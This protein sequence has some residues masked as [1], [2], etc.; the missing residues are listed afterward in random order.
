MRPALALSFCLVASS[1]AT[2]ERAT[3]NDVD[4]DAVKRVEPKAAAPTKPSEMIAGASAG[5]LI[6]RAL[7]RFL[8]ERVEARHAEKTSAVWASAWD[9]AL[10]AVS[11]ACEE[12]P[13]ASDLGAFVRARVT[14][15]VELEKD[16]ERGVLLP[17]DV[18]K[19]LSAVLGAVDESV[20]ELRAANA[21]GTMAPSPRL[22][23]GELVIHAPLFPL[24]INSPFGVREDPFTHQK[25]YHNGVDLD[26]RLGDPVMAAAAGLVVYAGLQG[27]Y[28]KQ[29]VLDHGD[30]VRTHYSHLSKILV[31]PGQTVAEG[32]AIALVGS[33]GRSTGPHLHFAVTNGEDFLDPTAVLD[34]PFS[35]IATQ[36]K[37]GTEKEKRAFA[38]TNKG[39][40][41][42]IHDVGRVGHD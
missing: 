39:D 24:V 42:E 17:N 15:E 19:R 23:D 6:D 32:D 35:A 27:G 1:C 16:K 28:G 40:T 7:Q 37:V 14:F 4:E 11:S 3:W 30:G 22:G 10:Y 29:V 33:T 36:V 21:P 41:V 34:I 12:A 18:D 31:E 13:R 2:P 20:G 25:R 8:N 9:D 26:G 38:L 5:V